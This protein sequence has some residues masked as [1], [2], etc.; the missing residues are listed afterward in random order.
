MKK[1]P[2]ILLLEGLAKTAT[3][4][5]EKLGFTDVTNYTT[6]FDDEEL[7]EKIKD[8]EIVGI[9]SRTNLTREI[10]EKLPNLKT[11]G[12]FC[13]G[14]N[15][16]DL[17]AAKELGINVFNAPFSNTRSVAELV[18]GE[19]I[20]LSR[21]IFEKST[22]AHSGGWLKSA[23]NSYEIKGKTLGIIGYGNIGKQ[24]SV[25]AES[26]GMNVIFFDPLPTLGIGNA[27]KKESLE[28]LLKESDFVTL[29]VPDLVSTRNMISTKEFDLMKNG[30]FLINASRGKVVDIEELKNNLESGKILGAALDVFPEE[31]KSKTEKFSSPL[32]G[33]YNVILTPHIG[34][35][36]I[37]AQNNIG[38][39]V[40]EKLF[41]YVSHGST[42]GSV[43]LPQISLKKHEE[44]SVRIEHIHKNI[45]GI[46][47]E[48]NK[49][50][51]ENNIQI[52]SQFLETNKGIG[53][54]VLDICEA[55]DEILKQLQNI[56]GTIKAR[57][58][59]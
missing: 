6:S 44:K 56:K 17:E 39:E 16:V 30:S 22:S 29:H 21:G 46:L 28:D 52:I 47:A 24:V 25:L 38:L 31:P 32:Q 13:I 43:N 12:C 54:V 26:M 58:I 33:L 40:S 18:I 48:I 59:K 42:I 49:I 5:F 35:S 34:G 55:N 14:T 27:T 37:E 20:M 10:L 45:S 36:T 8:A 19:I 9:R 15:Q 23:I 50:F 53:Y 57:L 4:N 1:N 51:G 11:I 3:D 7:I 2:K 41:N